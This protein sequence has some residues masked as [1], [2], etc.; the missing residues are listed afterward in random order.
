M[1]KLGVTVTRSALS[2]ILA[3]GV[4]SAATVAGDLSKYRDC[5]LGTDLSAVAKQT[6]MSPSQAKAIHR[7][8]AL[9]QELEWRPQPLGWSSKSEPAQDVLFSFYGGELF[10]IAVNYDRYGTEGLTTDDIVEAISAIYGVAVRLPALAETSQGR[11]GDQEEVV[12]RWQDPQYHF[13]LIRSSYGPSF[14]LVGIL[15]RLE[16]PAQAA[17]LE[18]KRLDDLE[19]PQREAARI[20]SEEEAARAKL[21]K[22]RLVNKPKFRP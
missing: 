8:P 22:A 5:Q 1:T 20:A 3:L 11:Y 13:D 19:E 9:I 12:A 17:V 10:R 14:R 6:G 16:A 7:R 21:E 2:S 15:K 18:A 4:I